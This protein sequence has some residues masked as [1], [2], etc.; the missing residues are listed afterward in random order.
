MA[1]GGLLAALR[2]RLGGTPLSEKEALDSQIVTGTFCIIP[3]QAKAWRGR[4]VHG[5]RASAL[6]SHLKRM[7]V[8]SDPDLLSPESV[9]NHHD[10]LYFP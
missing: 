1:H 10:L 8:N 4:G 5:I 7:T 2:T 3:A 9:L 6:M